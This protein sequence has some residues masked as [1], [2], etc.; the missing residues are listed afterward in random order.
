[1]WVLQRALNNML[2]IF[3]M[4][5][6]ETNTNWFLHASIKVFL[7]ECLALKYHVLKMILREADLHTNFLR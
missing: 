6:H 3:S 1:M 5:I 2:T 4:Y 7:I